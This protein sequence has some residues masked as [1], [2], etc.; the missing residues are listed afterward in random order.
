MYGTLISSMVVTPLTISL[1][2][3]VVLF[4]TVRDVSDVNSKALKP[5]DATLSGIVMLVIPVHPDT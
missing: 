5:I 1:L 3:D 2:S 4:G